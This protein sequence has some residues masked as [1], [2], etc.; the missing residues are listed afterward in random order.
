MTEMKNTSLLWFL[1][2][3]IVVYYLRTK[4]GKSTEQLSLADNTT[5]Y[6]LRQ[7]YE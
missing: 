2:A 4:R 6:I 7:I 3:F 5:H 1:V